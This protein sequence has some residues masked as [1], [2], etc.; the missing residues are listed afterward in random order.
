MRTLKTLAALAAILV[1]AAC[2]GREQKRQIPFDYKRGFPLKW[3]VLT[4]TDGGLAV[5]EE[6]DKFT[7]SGDTLTHWFLL[8][9]EKGQ[10]KILSSYQNP[11]GDTIVMRTYSL[12][13]D[14]YKES[15]CEF[16]WIDKDKGI[17][18]VTDPHQKDYILVT[19]GHLSEYPIIS[20]PPEDYFW[21]QD[22]IDQTE[23]PQ[24]ATPDPAY[25]GTWVI[26]PDSYDWVQYIISADK[27]D[28]IGPNTLH[29]ILGPLTWEPIDE[30][31]GNADYP[32]GYKITGI[33][34]IDNEPTYDV[35]Y[36][37]EDGQ[38]LM[39]GK[40]PPPHEAVSLF[41]KQLDVA[42]DHESQPAAPENK[43][44]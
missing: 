38:S 2:G 34:S 31:T 11:T 43:T 10:H 22:E 4:E 8:A 5:Y 26:A 14:F 12:D 17:A 25:F 28:R 19:D 24:P 40:W 37:S 33:H 29:P 20:N 7:I 30:P 13:W 36:I 41:F 6:P 39:T 1:L 15:C 42:G 18:K 32:K 21:L 27:V 35:F 9:G 16:V 3:T 23:I 44:N